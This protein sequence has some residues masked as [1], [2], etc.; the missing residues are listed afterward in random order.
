MLRKEIWIRPDDGRRIQRTT[1]TSQDCTD[2]SD[3]E[4]LSKISAGEVN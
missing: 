4:E 2:G 1:S 3:D